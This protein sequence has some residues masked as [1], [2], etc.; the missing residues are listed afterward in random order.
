MTVVF[1]VEKF[2]EAYNEALPM[3]KRHYDEIALNQDCVPFAPDVHRYHAAEIAGSLVIVT[4]REA[5]RLVGYASVIVGTRMHNVT[6]ISAFIES[7]WLAP[8][9]RGTGAGTGLFDA[10]ESAARARGAITAHCHSKIAQPALAF[11]LGKRGYEP[12]EVVHSK[13]LGDN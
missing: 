5:G 9:C 4:A 2:S 13:L 3:L 11:L 6:T 1:Q 10:V 7:V 8:E 12:V